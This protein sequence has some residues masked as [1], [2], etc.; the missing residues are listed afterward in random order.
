MAITFGGLA[1]G[2]D[3]GAIIDALMAIE[4]QPIKRLENDKSFYKSQL[5]A[6][7]ELDGKLEGLLAKAEAIDTTS[8][9]NTPKATAAT[10]GYFTATSSSSAS[11]GSYQI[12]VIGLAQR[13]K[14][15]S[16]GVADKAANEFGTGT[17]SLTVGGTPTAITIDS[18]NNSLEGM[19]AAINAADAGVTATIINDGT[20]SPYRMILTGDTVNDTFSLD[21]SGL[22]GG[23]Y[24]NPTM[25]NKQ[26]AQ[27][28]HIQ[29]DNIDIYSDTNTFEEAIQGVSLEVLKSDAAVSTTLT[30]SSNPD[31]TESKIKDFANAYNGVVNFIAAQSDADWGNDSS[32][33]SVKRRMQDILTTEI[34]GSGSFST[35]SEL[36]FETQRD[37]TLVVNSTTLSDAMTKDFDGV[38][39]LF[40]GEAGVDGIS[41]I[42]SGYLDSMTDSIDGL[43]ATRKKSTDS[44]TR[45]I[46][47]RIENLEARMVSREKTLQ[48]QFS[49]M[50]ELVSG[51]NSQS[52][53][54]LQQMASMP[55]IGR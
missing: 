53:F 21:A 17:L 19:A 48:A 49:A 33:R 55:V 43:L 28:A 47:R 45:R 11:M 29:I 12:E 46:D 14:D 31:A 6:F 52:S 10:E 51:L 37:G 30:L 1:T 3:T 20:A 16:D 5:Q 38:I 9:L 36:G 15:V 2:M 42:F 25:V 34:S 23:T 26:A 13:Q 35:L 27:Q 24:P 54:L 44:N 8:E 22:S 32:I 39:S 18:S 7:T 4:R 50:E 41:K 40:T